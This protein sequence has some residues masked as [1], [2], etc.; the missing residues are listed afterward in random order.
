MYFLSI[1]SPWKKLNYDYWINGYAI[2]D[3]SKIFNDLPSS[4]FQRKKKEEK[5]EEENKSPFACIFFLFLL[6]KKLNYGYWINGYSTQFTIF[7]KYL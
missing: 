2:H 5:E 1:F 3:I 6:R 7:R 4:F